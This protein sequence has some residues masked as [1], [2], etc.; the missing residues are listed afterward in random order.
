MAHKHQRGLQNATCD[1]QVSACIQCLAVRILLWASN[2]VG[3][4]PV[5][6]VTVRECLALLY[7]SHPRA[8]LINYGH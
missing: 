2:G 5:V 7:L 4:R 1:S 8:E 6:C 3:R